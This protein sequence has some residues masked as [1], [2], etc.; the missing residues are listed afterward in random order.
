MS[1]RPFFSGAVCWPDPLLSSPFQ[2]PFQGEGP[3]F[4]VAFQRQPLAFAL[5][6]GLRRRDR[7]RQE[8]AVALR[9]Q[10]ESLP[11]HDRL[12]VLQERDD[13]AFLGDVLV[14]RLVA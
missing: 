4:G 5:W 3:S 12:D 6:S 2:G 7:L 9:R 1:D 11:Y 14:D 10:L 8:H 13:L